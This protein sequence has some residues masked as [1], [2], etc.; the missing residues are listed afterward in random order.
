VV[1]RPP[2]S[3]R[4]VRTLGLVT[5]V[6]MLLGGYVLLTVN[7]PDSRRPAAVS[8]PTTRPGDPS[9]ASSQA[10]A[11]PGPDSV[12]DG[13]A[14]PAT[15]FRPDAADNGPMNAT[16]QV[17]A[18][19]GPA[20]GPPAGTV[21]VGGR[22]GLTP[23]RG[24]RP[25]Q[26]TGTGYVDAAVENRLPG[27]PGWKSTR[28]GR[29]RSIEG[30]ADAAGVTAG[31][32]VHVYVS[33]SA[34]TFRIQLLRIGWYAGV[35]ARSVWVSDPVK[36]GRQV[37]ARQDRSTRMFSAPWRVSATMPTGGLVAGD[38]LLKLL[39][40]DGASSFVPLVVR[41]PHSTGALLMLNST[42]TWQAYN[43]WGGASTYRADNGKDD[44]EESASRSVVA[45]YDRPY[46]R[47]FGTG[48]FLDEEY[49][50]VLAAER[51]GLKLNYAADVDLHGRSEV[52]DGALGIAL[53]G[54]SE[55]WSR[56]MRAALTAARERGANLAFFGANDIYRRIRMKSSPLGPERRMVNYK[57]GTLDPVK[58]ADTT[59]DWPK[60]P[61]SNP[62]ADITGVQYRCAHAR[63]DMVITNPQGWLFRGLGLRAGQK[64]P[65][66]V[67]SEFDRVMLGIKT[68]PRPLQVMAHSPISCYGKPEFSDLVWYSTPSGS[69]VF[70]AGTL[71]WNAALSSSHQLTRRVVTSVTERVMRAIALPRA[72]ETTPAVDNVARHYSPAGVPLDA[73]GRPL[74][75]PKPAASRSRQRLRPA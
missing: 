39:G 52:A 1:L 56:Q 43:P 2:S 44:E 46:A 3:R 75:T 26:P 18:V 13:S 64:L 60:R 72:G 67:G 14:P 74:S 21:P 28:S 42:L 22:R 6:S 4:A 65:G 58:T 37:A 19:A 45:S 70:A 38:Y 27:T 17:R 62:A 8:A 59:A 32:D 7:S 29:S 48:G 15:G 11:P 51:L 36:G 73:H 68:T 61:F 41:E 55:Y 40:S 63:A 9:D 12:V 10:A 33:S 71:D 47:S 50:L 49:N 69:G 25:S 54:H 57:D 35:G 53:L 24:T 66:L 5:S 31:D 30:F 20:G 34:P 16:D 23:G